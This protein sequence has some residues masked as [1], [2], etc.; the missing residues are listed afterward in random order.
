MSTLNHIQKHNFGT[1]NTAGNNGEIRNVNRFGLPF[2]VKKSW[3]WADYL[4]TFV[5]NVDNRY[6]IGLQSGWPGILQ[7]KQDN[8][9]KLDNL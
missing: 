1:S 8:E 7:F 4:S 6:V 9:S 5:P 2:A 3:F